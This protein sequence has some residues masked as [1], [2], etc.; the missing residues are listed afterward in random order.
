M[1]KSFKFAG[2]EGEQ[3]MLK[4]AEINDFS[5]FLDLKSE[6]NE[7]LRRSKDDSIFLTWE[8]LYTYWKYFGK[9]RKLRILL[10]EDKNK[11]IAIAPL[12]QQRVNFGS[13][14]IQTMAE[15]MGDRSLRAASAIGY[16]VIEPMGYRSTDYTGLILTEREAECLVMLFNYLT[17]NDDWDFI[18]LFDI[19]GTSMI[20][21]AISR[22][23]EFIPAIEI[24]KG[25][26]CP[27]I[28]LPNSVEGFTQGLEGRFR[29]DLRRNLR[30]LKKN[31]Q[32]VILKGYDEFGSVEEAMNIF[33]DLHQER[34]KSKNM[35]G[36]FN[37][38]KVRDW[39]L[40]WA[41]Q[42]ANKGWLA[43]HFLTANDEPIAAHLAFEYKGV[44]HSGLTGLNSDFYGYGVGNLL[45]QHIIENCI[46]KGIKEF[47]FMKGSEP[48]K[49][50]WDATYRRNTNIRIMNRKT[51][52][53]LY[54]IG[55]KAI[56]KMKIERILG[57]LH[58]I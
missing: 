55:I 36:V 2:S 4:I 41:R 32:R 38:Q 39:Y 11:I 34:W 18:Y 17:E 5:H 49:F 28:S 1:H 25:L 48:Y 31:Y 24:A 53:L 27:Y 20:P 43:L 46:R 12:R 30:N 56:K 47:D 45:T 40:E 54:D 10:V 50:K 51:A 3:Q 57:K 21:E 26:M 16:N 9:E 15:P 52:S 19:P 22:I 37:S 13:Q 7:V 14:I 44:I 23:S 8:W 42:F 58:K 29:K 35:P 6:W 33:F